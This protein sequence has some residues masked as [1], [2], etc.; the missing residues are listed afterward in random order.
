MIAAI[1]LAIS[2]ISSEG[3]WSF[4]KQPENGF[5]YPSSVSSAHTFGSP[6][7]KDSSRRIVKENLAAIE[8]LFE[9]YYERVF[10][11][12][13]GLSNNWDVA[14][15]GP[16]ATTDSHLRDVSFAASNG[17]ER[18]SL[19]YSPEARNMPGTMR[20]AETNLVNVYP[21]VIQDLI[22]HGDGNAKLLDRGVT[23][24]DGLG[25][26][27]W[28]ACSEFDYAEMPEPFDWTAGWP[29]GHTFTS[30]FVPIRAF[31]SSGHGYPGDTEQYQPHFAYA[32]LEPVLQRDSDWEKALY[33][34]DYTFVGAN[35]IFRQL[36]N[37]FGCSEDLEY[38]P[39]TQR[40]VPDEYVV[41]HETIMN[42][43]VT[44]VSY[45]ASTARIL[46]CHDR[47]MEVPVMDAYADCHVSN[48]YETCERSSYSHNTESYAISVDQSTMSFYFE[49]P[50]RLR[51]LYYGTAELWSTSRV[52][53]S[54]APSEFD[55]A[56]L[57]DPYAGA[58]A[59]FGAEDRTVPFDGD[60]LREDVRDD[61][62]YAGTERPATLEA[63]YDQ[64]TDAFVCKL[65]FSDGETIML[66]M[67]G[68]LAWCI[69]ESGM[70]SIP[71]TAT[72]SAYGEAS[73]WHTVHPYA[74]EVEFRKL[75]P[76]YTPGLRGASRVRSA[77]CPMVAS[78]VA[79]Y[80]SFGSGYDVLDP[81]FDWYDLEYVLHS[82]GIEYAC[83]MPSFSSWSALSTFPT[84]YS[85]M[86]R[87]V[88]AEVVDDVIP[89]SLY[90]IIPVGLEYYD[91]S[92][93]ASQC[94]GGVVTPYVFVDNDPGDH[95][96]RLLVVYDDG[97][98]CRG[99]KLPDSTDPDWIRYSVNAGVYFTLTT[100]FV[101]EGVPPLFTLPT[102]KS[103]TGRT[104]GGIVADWDFHAL[105]LERNNQ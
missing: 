30:N 24:G 17:G 77:V 21:T 60:L 88:L 98:V 94:D 103:A 48:R 38:A 51:D 15:Y 53:Y 84:A 19:A 99:F 32:L 42:S 95:S 14:E 64:G 46:A 7:H 69:Y 13:E 58:S 36:S 22:Y 66:R 90:G 80:G 40:L 62:S 92:S 104:S 20:F 33:P 102:A 43:C 52:E 12:S 11:A 29:D 28:W 72:F 10:F 85:A 105:K 27:V 89:P 97:G 47:T 68:V 18:V 9:A 1:L 91:I 25:R 83:D 61:P 44:N 34:N 2:T 6:D 86:R 59:H 73:A 82:G 16:R 49:E 55:C 76:A 70:D 65:V 26:S 3:L 54:W 71:G 75:F 79:D 81:P 31:D 8:T 50:V 101:D 100:E 87:R 56:K 23:W 45:L 67:E 78:V 37:V 41:G 35:S 5:T 57:D 4:M 96:V 63:S 39:F 74:Q 93:L